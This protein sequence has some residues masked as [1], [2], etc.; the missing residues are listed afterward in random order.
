MKKIGVEKV[1]WLEGYHEPK[2]YTI[3]QIK[4]IRAKYQLKLKELKRGA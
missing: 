4:D 2:K 3:E 1:E